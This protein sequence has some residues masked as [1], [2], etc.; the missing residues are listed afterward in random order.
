[1]LFVEAP[2][3]GDSVEVLELGWVEVSVKDGVANEVVYGSGRVSRREC[4]P[5]KDHVSRLSFRADWEIT[6]CRRRGYCKIRS[7]ALGLGGSWRYW[8]VR[9][10]IVA[11]IVKGDSNILPEHPEGI[12]VSS[13]VHHEV[14]RC[15]LIPSAVARLYLCPRLDR[16]RGRL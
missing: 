12:D 6:V 15:W 11:W 3:L 7:E 10:H 14:F 16:L 8:Y 9:E 2:D 1:M 13:D 5:A 4:C